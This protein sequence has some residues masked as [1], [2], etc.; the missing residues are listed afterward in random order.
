[1]VTRWQTL[2]HDNGVGA[3]DRRG[4]VATAPEATTVVDIIVNS[5]DHTLL[6]AAVGAAASWTR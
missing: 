1:M 2:R 4:V 6:E 5:E 3:R